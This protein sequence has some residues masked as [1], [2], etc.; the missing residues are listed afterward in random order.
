[1]AGGAQVSTASESAAAWARAVTRHPPHP[2]SHPSRALAALSTPPPTWPGSSQGQHW[3]EENPGL[4]HQRGYCAVLCPPQGHASLAHQGHAS[5]MQ[6]DS[7]PLMERRERERCHQLWFHVLSRG[8]HPRFTHPPICHQAPL[9]VFPWVHPLPHLCLERVASSCPGSLDTA[10]V[11][12]FPTFLYLFKLPSHYNS[13][14]PALS[15]LIVL[16]CP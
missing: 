11:P 8:Q 15:S 10:R 9:L 12:S 1:M 14:A 6:R 4:A 13:S 5:E 3:A 16:V 7:S 2:P